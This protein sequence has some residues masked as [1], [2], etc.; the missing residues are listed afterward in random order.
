MDNRNSAAGRRIRVDLIDGFLGAGKTTFIRR[1]MEYL[2][3]KGVSYVILEN[4]FGAAG[5]DAKLLGGNVRELSGGCI[6]CGQKVNFHNLLIELSAE[7][8][9]IIVE[10]SGVFN[11][12]DFFD[13]MDSPEV[14][15]VAECGMMVG[16][17]DPFALDAMTEVD[18]SV[19]FDELICAGAILLS[20]TDRADR[21]TLDRAKERLSDLL[22]GEI[23]ILDARRV[24]FE[25]L[26]GRGPV[27]RGH[28]RR[29]QDHAAL[30]QS[31]VV[32]PERA[33]S[34]TS[35][36]EMIARMTSGEAGGVLRVKGSVKA[37]N[38]GF[39]FVNATADDFEILTGCGPV[40]LNVIGR[41]IDRRRLKALV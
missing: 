8:E 14:G 38:G 37:E 6:C 19:L 9:R 7:A 25:S 28:L 33:Y 23:P 39:L 36:K 2:E 29:I 17:V 10:P 5:V 32:R 21:E 40:A 34:E 31:T 16:L 26:T 12:D 27:R 18:Q 1:Y 13:V 30:F 15:R 22:G 4:E 41:N 24:D 20:R 3:E 11:A 35:L